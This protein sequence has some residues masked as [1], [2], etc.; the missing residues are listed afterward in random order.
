VCCCVLLD[1]AASIGETIGI[2]KKVAVEGDQQEEEKSLPPP[3]EGV[4]AQE[5]KH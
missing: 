1:L 5:D 3:A 4:E 2:L